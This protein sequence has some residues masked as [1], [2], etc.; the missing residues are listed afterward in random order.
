MNLHLKVFFIFFLLFLPLQMQQPIYQSY[1]PLR[2]DR[3]AVDRPNSSRQFSYNVDKK[4]EGISDR[5][6]NGDLDGAMQSLESMMDWNISKYEKAVGIS[7]H[8]LYFCATRQD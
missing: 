1:H 7:I 6:G 5:F 4:F 2:A 3:E 8:G